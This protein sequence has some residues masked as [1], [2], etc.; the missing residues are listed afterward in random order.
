MR[1][2]TTSVR[3]TTPR[4]VT[5]VEGLYPPHPRFTPPPAN[6]GRTATAAPR[7]LTDTTLRPSPTAGKPSTYRTANPTAVGPVGAS[8]WAKTLASATV[9]ALAGRRDHRSLQRWL[10]PA[11][12]ETLVANIS[13]APSAGSSLTA[14]PLNARIFEIDERTVEFSVTVWDQ[15]R[16]RA[17][18]GRL[19][20]LRHRWL[21]T[22]LQVG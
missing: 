16:V 21:A 3:S 15:H 1:A 13:A 8:S 5:F 14:R 22:A 9:D 2:L 19:M 10:T 4:A 12:Y 6:T 18:A 7:L 17:V 11:A 20:K